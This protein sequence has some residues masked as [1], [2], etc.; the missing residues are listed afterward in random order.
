MNLYKLVTP[1]KTIWFGSQT[2]AKSYRFQNKLKKDS[3]LDL[4][5]VPTKKVEL[6]EWLN[7]QG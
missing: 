2:E 6:L 4:V 3:T 7:A 5:D 1:E